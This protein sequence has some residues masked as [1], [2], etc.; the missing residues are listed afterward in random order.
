[1]KYKL[2]VIDVDGTLLNDQ[3]QITP[4]TKSA[5]LKAQQM[6]V[7]IVLASGRPTGGILPLAKELELNNY[8]G[9]VISYNGA[10]IIEMQTGNLLFEKRI[11]PELIPYLDKKA[12]KNGF[13]IFTY[14]ENYLIT[15]CADDPYVQQEANLNNMHIRQVSN[16]P[17][18]IDFEPC[19]CI[20]ASDN[21][22]ELV[23]LENHWKRNWQV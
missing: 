2:L 12:K 8:G 7:H 14:L 11:N 20:L 15:D 10:Q 1:M 6:G 16:F 9:Y 23:G 18:A 19:K 4:H 3:K 21:E 5:I 22:K 17:N 13:T